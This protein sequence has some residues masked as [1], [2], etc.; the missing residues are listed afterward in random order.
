M[1]TEH[2]NENLTEMLKNVKTDINSAAL[3]RTVMMTIIELC[4]VTHHIITVSLTDCL[5][6][7]DSEAEKEEQ[8]RKKR[9]R[10]MTEK[11]VKEKEREMTEKTTKKKEEKIMIK[12]MRK[13]AVKRRRE[14]MM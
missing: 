13:T 8:E 3:L 5:N 1:L 10:E 12:M 9:E 6:E 7:E 2:R 11:T 4:E 14:M